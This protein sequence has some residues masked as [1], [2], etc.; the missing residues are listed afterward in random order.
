MWGFMCVCVLT[1][2][3]PVRVCRGGLSA[4]RFRRILLHRLPNQVGESEMRRENDSVIL[5]Q[6]YGQ[7]DMTGFTAIRNHVCDTVSKHPERRFLFWSSS[8]LHMCRMAH[9]SGI[10]GGSFFFFGILFT[11]KSPLTQRF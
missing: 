6:G 9:T 7:H 3:I 4:R 5:L 2:V 11:L 1:R 8:I 10:A